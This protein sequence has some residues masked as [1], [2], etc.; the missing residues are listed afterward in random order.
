MKLLL[1]CY[2]CLFYYFLLS[3]QF[4]LNK[5]FDTLFNY[6]LGGL[7]S[8]SPISPKKLSFGENK[9]FNVLVYAL[10]KLSI[11][12]RVLNIIVGT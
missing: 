2:T 11:R 3:N 8:G 12:N 10:K 7:T 6:R 9:L 1:S 5:L 4:L